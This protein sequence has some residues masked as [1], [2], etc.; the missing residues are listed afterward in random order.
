MKTGLNDDL[1]MLD[2][3]GG[4][5]LFNDAPHPDRENNMILFFLFISLFLIGLKAS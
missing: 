5:S 4:G 2:G 1:F 3:R